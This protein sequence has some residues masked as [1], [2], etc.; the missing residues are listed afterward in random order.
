[1][2]AEFKNPALS[3]KKKEVILQ[4]LHKLNVEVRMNEKMN[5]K[6]C[7]VFLKLLYSP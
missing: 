2:R 6:K 3:G 4:K 7:T 1:M 5:T